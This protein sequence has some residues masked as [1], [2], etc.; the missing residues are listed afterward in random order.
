MKIQ[1]AFWLYLIIITFDGF[2][3][4][5]LS[6][7]IPKSFYSKIS[8]DLKL[9]AG[10]E[11]IHN[12]S[13]GEITWQ[14]INEQAKNL[15]YGFV[16][17]RLGI[18]LNNDQNKNLFSPY[19]YGRMIIRKNYYIYLYSRATNKITDYDI[20]GF[21][22][23]KLE[24]SRFGLVAAETDAAGVG[25]K[26]DWLHLQYGRGRE[27]FGPVN[28]INLVMNESSPSFDYG[29]I[30]FYHKKFRSRYFHG[31]LENIDGVNRY[32]NGRGIEY[33]NRN[34]FL[35]SFSEIIIYSGLNRPI[36]F[37]YLN[38][39]A[40]HLELEFNDRQN[41]SNTG[42]GNAVWL[43]SFDHF[44]NSKFRITGNF[45][46]DEFILDKEEYDTGKRNGLAYSFRIFRPLNKQK[47]QYGYGLYY[48]NIGSKV[49]RHENGNNNFVSRGLPLG[50]TYGSNG[51][52]IGFDG[53][54]FDLSNFIVK[55]KYGKR[56]I[57]GDSIIIDPYKEYEEY[58]S[59]NT[60]S[61]SIYESNFINAELNYWFNKKNR[62]IS[63]LEILSNINSKLDANFIIGFD[64]YFS[65]K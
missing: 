62:F 31:F 7:D 21:S 30:G 1:K 42:A 44:F 48:V 27:V 51:L 43:L 25:F 11:W 13:L 37:T 49:F 65:N 22:G 41:L 12:S 15:D 28:Q 10:K 14:N 18:K 24:R 56:I 36:D 5:I 23:K 40:S 4:K 2:I 6:Q 46:I 45:L 63:R 29:L 3:N 17:H 9:D 60:I 59:K 54:F 50:W 8:Y 57:G 39:I 53:H 35:I 55:I 64:K 33:N 19:F 52:E 34:D 16:E 26:N 61:N 32:I 47:Y 58:N 38:P 20:N